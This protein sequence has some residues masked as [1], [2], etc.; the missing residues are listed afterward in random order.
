MRAP[1]EMVEAVRLTPSDR[2]ERALRCG[3]HRPLPAAPSCSDCEQA[4]QDLAL[5]VQILWARYPAFMPPAELSDFMDG[6]PDDLLHALMA[7]TGQSHK[8]ASWE[9]EHPTCDVIRA[10][11]EQE[12]D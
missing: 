7:S 8:A 5:L 6:L 11:D 4:V 2:C 9:S 1:D 10:L 3:D 12:D